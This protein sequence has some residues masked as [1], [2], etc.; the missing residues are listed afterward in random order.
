MIMDIKKT[1]Y[2]VFDVETTGLYPWNGDRILEIGAVKIKGGK[3]T[4]TFASLVNP[5][6]PLREGAQ[7][8]NKITS[9]MIIQAP[10]AGKILPRFLDFIGGACCVAHNARFDADFVGYELAKIGRKMRDETPVLDTMKMARVSL[11]QLNS[12]RL[13]GVARYLGVEADETHRAL[14]DAETTAAVFTRLMDTSIQRG[15]RDFRQFCREFGIV[16]TG[17]KMEKKK[18]DYLF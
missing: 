4:D 8:I 3:K 16:K 5:D 15:I 18:Q 11:P 7:R 1:E 6:R 13:E 12:Y 17:F 14:A 2:V 10:D 9:E